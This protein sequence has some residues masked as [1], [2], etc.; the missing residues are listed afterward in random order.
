M[1]TKKTADKKQKQPEVK[2]NGLF[3]VQKI[4]VKRGTFEAP[5]VPAIFEQKGTARI[6]LG[7]NVAINKLS[8]DNYEVILK[9]KVE[10]KVDD[11]IIF[12]IELVQAG[13]F[14]IKG[15]KDEQVKIFAETMCPQIL[16]PYAA[17]T[18]SCLTG[19]GGFPSLHLTP[20]NFERLYREKQA[21]MQ[22][23]Q[24]K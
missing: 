15:F 12:L 4:Y 23:N 7:I 24:K 8:N 16:F 13:I 6:S 19:K 1:D 18:I 11:K 17:E 21:Q 14:T 9:L 2:P 22:K 5:N 20:I 10:N 3:V